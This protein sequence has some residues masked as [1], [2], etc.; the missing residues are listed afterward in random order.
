MRAIVALMLSC[1]GACSS[2]DPSGATSDGASKTDAGADTAADAAAAADSRASSD[3]G[4]AD[5]LTLRCTAQESVD[6]CEER[7]KV[8]GERIDVA[9]GCSKGIVALACHVDGTFSSIETCVGRDSGD[10]YILSASY[11]LKP[12][13]YPTFR[14]CSDAE[15]A[16][17]RTAQGTS[18]P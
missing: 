4:A 13:N 6:G 3:A 11:G 9:R 14:A 8:H 10:L 12:P 15:F 2:N 16:A 1:V 7:C 18:C 17:A 5:T